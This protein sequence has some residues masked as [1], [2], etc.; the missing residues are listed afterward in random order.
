MYYD[1]LLLLLFLISRL[2]FRCNS[3]SFNWK[4]LILVLFTLIQ[5]ENWG[6]YGVVCVSLVCLSAMSLSV[7]YVIWN[8]VLA[9]RKNKNNRN[10]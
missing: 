4:H 8:D 6:E 7:I 2:L 10:K 3:S 1:N 5:I 9:M